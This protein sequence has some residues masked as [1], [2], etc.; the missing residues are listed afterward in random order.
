[1]KVL[2]EVRSR[3]LSELPHCKTHADVSK[4]FDACQV[5]LL[6]S[7]AP[8]GQRQEMWRDIK[9]KLSSL[10]RRPEVINDAH[11]IID[12]LLKS[13]ISSEVVAVE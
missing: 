5:S 1:M 3:I 10:S 8:F 6:S 9:N 12:K 7:K 2:Q 4:L 11:A 13:S